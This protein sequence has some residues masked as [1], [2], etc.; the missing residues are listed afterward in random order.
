M[1]QCVSATSPLLTFQTCH[2]HQQVIRRYLPSRSRNDICETYAQ[3]L[4]IACS[5][6]DNRCAIVNLLVTTTRGAADMEVGAGER[7]AASSK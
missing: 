2:V 5:L 1:Y 3:S 6:A 7:P 4:L